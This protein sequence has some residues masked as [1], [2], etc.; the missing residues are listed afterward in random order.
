MSIKKNLVYNTFY[1]ILIMIIPFI[2]TPYVA[3]VIGVNGVGIQSY[4]FSIVSYFTMFAM[5]G[6][7]NH[8]NRNIAMVRENKK[9]LSKNFFAIY[10]VQFIAASLMIVLYI[11]Y[12]LVFTNE[13]KGIFFIQLIY[14]FSSLLD[15]NWFYFGLEQF[16]LTVVRNIIIKIISILCVFTFVKSR[17]DIYIYSLILAVSN[18]LSQIVLWPFLRKYIM[19]YKITLNDIIPHIKPILVLFVPVIAISIYK[20]MD[21]IML[22]LISDTVQVGL[23]ENAERII[24]MPIGVIISLGT[25]MLPKM[26][27]LYATKDSK[28]VTKYIDVSMNFV[29]FLAFGAMFGLIGVS[30]TL[31][32]IFLGNEFIDCIKLVPIL[33]ITI[34][35]LSWANVIRTQFL[36]PKNKN[37]TYV[38]S[39]ILGA[40]TNL[41]INLLFISR[42][43]ALGAVIGTIFAEGIVAI[44]QSIIVKDLLDIKGYLKKN[45]FFIFPGIFMCIVVIY[46]GNLLGVT[47]LTGIIQIIVGLIIYMSIS[48]I[49]MVYIKNYV[50]INLLDKIGKKL[51]IK[52]DFYI[53]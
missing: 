27:N 16:K 50:L 49:Y 33:S 46:I 36:I 2:T 5:L 40:I 10:I 42:Y 4:T 29:M 26:S 43:G 41:I 47:I 52:S 38:I 45:L 3:R 22:G 14:I 51:N 35:F 28:E 44:Y 6:I 23:Y 19:F 9:L 53:S 25:V 13:Y 24:G 8:G 39:T 12:I 17:N 1:Q 48:L 21:K 20:L 34:V 15:I 32:P 31:V 30:K 11:M 37:K 7:N 18:L